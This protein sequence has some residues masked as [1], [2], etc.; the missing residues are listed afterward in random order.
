MQLK[1]DSKAPLV[2]AD[3]NHTVQSVAN[4]YLQKLKEDSPEVYSKLEQDSQSL[5]L[6]QVQVDLGFKVAGT[7]EVQML[8]T[9]VRGKD[10]PELL[11][12]TATIREDGSLDF[13][14]V[15]D[16]DEQ[17][18][19]TDVEALIAQ[20]I[21]TE[22]KAV[23]SNYYS[24][25]LQE[26]AGFK[27]GNFEIEIYL[28]LDNETAVIWYITENKIVQEI[29]LQITEEHTIEAVIDHYKQLTE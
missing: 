19:F 7:E 22:F 6:L 21:P 29:E 11:T 12:V 3:L 5:I 8:T 10:L 17:S 4:T 16:N 26:A 13:G 18:N 20:G 14:S 9:D 28:T 25:E 1:I 24:D 2:T 23:E 15:K 27:V